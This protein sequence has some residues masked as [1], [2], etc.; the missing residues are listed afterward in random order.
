MG[1]MKLRWYPAVLTESCMMVNEK[2]ERKGKTVRCDLSAA[3]VVEFGGHLKP[4]EET[5]ILMEM[6][7]WELSM[8]T[9]D[10]IKLHSM[11][12]KVCHFGEILEMD[13]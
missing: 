5:I 13:F 9:R 2:K 7:W 4:S 3:L 6:F 12:I 8:E 11:L 10:Y 1:I